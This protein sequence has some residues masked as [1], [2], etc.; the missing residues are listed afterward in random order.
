[1]RDSP[2]RFSGGLAKPLLLLELMSKIRKACHAPFRVDLDPL[3]AQS[4]AL[5]G[6]PRLFLR[7]VNPAASIDDAE[8]RN[9]IAIAPKSGEG[10]ADVSRH[11]DRT[12]NARDI[13]VRGDTAGRD[14][15]HDFV[16]LGVKTG[17]DDPTRTVSIGVV[18]HR[19]LPPHSAEK[20]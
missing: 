20:A 18:G 15:A 11:P 14:R 16:D 12:E 5:F 10:E 13:A 7:R 8:P 17:T 1:M 4:I 6:A 9:V 2:S 3:F 19:D